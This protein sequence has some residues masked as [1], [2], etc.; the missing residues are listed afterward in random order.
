MKKLIHTFFIIS[1]LLF[2]SVSADTDTQLIDIE[3]QS[4]P[5]TKELNIDF[6]L[7]KFSSCQNMQD[8]VTEYIKN[9][10]S[11]SFQYKYRS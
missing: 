3:N 9:S 10:F 7:N 11:H 2:T 4:K 5:V 6:S 8:V 1:I